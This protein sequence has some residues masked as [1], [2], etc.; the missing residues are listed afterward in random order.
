MRADVDSLVATAFDLTVDDLRIMFEDFR[1]LDRGQP[2]LDGE[3]ASTVTRDVV[4]AT[5]A[6][7]TGEDEQPW[8]ERA[9]RAARSSARH[10]SYQPTTPG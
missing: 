9:D 8:A 3:P 4:L 5:H 1:L 7:R 6:R 10:R 2:A